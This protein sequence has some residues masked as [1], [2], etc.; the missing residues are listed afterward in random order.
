MGKGLHRERSCARR[1]SAP[2]RGSQALNR[3]AARQI[4]RLCDSQSCTKETNPII[5]MPGDITKQA[6]RH[7]HRH[8]G[9]M[10]SKRI[11]KEGRKKERKQVSFMC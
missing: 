4:L 5:E 10:D 11:G 1:T 7:R 6:R 8:T 9:E 2:D 3:D